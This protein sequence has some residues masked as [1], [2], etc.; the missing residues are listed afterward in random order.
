MLVGHDVMA[1]RLSRFEP[2]PGA[3]ESSEPSGV[4]APSPSGFVNG[5]PPAPP[6]SESGTTTGQHSVDPELE[7]AE[8]A[9]NGP[10]TAAPELP[11][12][13]SIYR[14]YF[15]FV[16]SSAKRLG[17]SQ[18]AMDDVVQEIFMV[19]HARL[20]TLQK[21]ES[22]RSWIY[23]ISRR[24][25]SDH[26]RS[27]RTRE[28]SQ[29]ALAREL[30]V[31]NDLPRTP[32]DLTQQSDQV[33]LLWSLLEEMDWAKREVFLLAELDEMTA[34][35][36]AEALEIPLNTAYSRLRAARHAFD[37]KLA[38]RAIRQGRGS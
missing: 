27:R 16:W 37:E 38:R 5:G 15:D 31:G 30:E 21:P 13:E 8:Q 3:S 36:I 11:P 9:P 24:T 33:K 25:V 22:L 23:G 6:V 19:I 26:H 7:P 1:A 32:F 28:A 18:A 10:T 35:E 4:A 12:F 29:V 34:P 17:V 2:S 20:G 14:Q